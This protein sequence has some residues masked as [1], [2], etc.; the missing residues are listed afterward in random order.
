MQRYIDIMQSKIMKEAFTIASQSY[1]ICWFIEYDEVTK[2]EIQEFKQ[3][4]LR[5]EKE[6]GV[7][8]IDLVIEFTKDCIT[9]Y[10]DFLDM[11]T[12]EI[13]G[14]I[15]ANRKI[16]NELDNLQYSARGIYADVGVVLEKYTLQQLFDYYID[17][18]MNGHSITIRDYLE[19]EIIKNEINK[20]K[21]Y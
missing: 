14:R 21:K 20:M 13:D 19:M 2:E 18:V 5:L 16:R 6:F 4:I 3:D 12:T 1:E 9:F 8:D 17:E 15:D 7:K 11:I 10:G